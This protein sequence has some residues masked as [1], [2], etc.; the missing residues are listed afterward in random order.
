[1]SYLLE[2]DEEKRNKVPKLKIPGLLVQCIWWI[3]MAGKES[4]WFVS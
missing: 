1:L 3:T 4:V 2:G